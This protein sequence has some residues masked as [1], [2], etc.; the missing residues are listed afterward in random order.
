MSARTVNGIT[1]RR[2]ESALF[3]TRDGGLTLK[4]ER[5]ADGWSVCELVRRQEPALWPERWHELPDAVQSARARGLMPFDETMPLDK[6][7]YA[8]NGHE[9][10]YAVRDRDS[11]GRL[12]TSS[13]DASH[14]DTCRCHDSD[15]YEPIPDW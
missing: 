11:E 2:G 1:L 3:Y 13:W 8:I 9:F 6:T 4:F 12:T 5:L 15:E 7:A 10:L 14:T